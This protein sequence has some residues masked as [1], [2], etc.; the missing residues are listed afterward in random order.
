LILAQESLQT[1]KILRKELMWS[2]KAK[3]KNYLWILKL[4]VSHFPGKQ[5]KNIFRHL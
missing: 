1:G 2:M 5:S 3:M 4:T